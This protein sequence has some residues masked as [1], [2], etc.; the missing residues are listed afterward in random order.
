MLGDGLLLHRRAAPSRPGGRGWIPA[1][2]GT[3]LSL[4]RLGLDQV[5]GQ[6]V[7]DG[8]SRDILGQE[9]ASVEAR[10]H[11]CAHAVPGR[12][13]QGRPRGRHGDVCGHSGQRKGIPLVTFGNCLAATARLSVAAFTR[14]GT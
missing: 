10:H 2:P 1:R 4:H 7:V 14:D 11:D 3:S 9:R 6:Q 5:I 8:P 13:E 12:R